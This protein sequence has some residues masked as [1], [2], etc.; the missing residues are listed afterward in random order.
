MKTKKKV[1]LSDFNDSAVKI[2][3]KQVVGGTEEGFPTE[4]SKLVHSGFGILD[5]E[6]YGDWHSTC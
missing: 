4:G 1:S 6:E 3:S 2:D 5:C